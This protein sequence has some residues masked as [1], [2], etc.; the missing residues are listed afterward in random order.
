MGAFVEELLHHLKD[1]AKGECEY[2]K[3]AF[4]LATDDCEDDARKFY[5]MAK[6]ERSH[7]EKIYDILEEEITDIKNKMSKKDVVMPRFLKTRYEECKE[8][9]NEKSQCAEEY[10]NAYESLNSIR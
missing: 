5:D 2:A 4:C 3:L 10:I 1:E 9:Y 8:L 6:E 7:A